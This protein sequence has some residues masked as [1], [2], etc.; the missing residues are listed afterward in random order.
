MWDVAKVQP[1]PVRVTRAIEPYIC[2]HGTKFASNYNQRQ[3]YSH[4]YKQL[5][6]YFYVSVIIGC[7]ERMEKL[8]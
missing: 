6:I 5:Y 3:K 7:N 8:D 4:V 2:K 1:Q